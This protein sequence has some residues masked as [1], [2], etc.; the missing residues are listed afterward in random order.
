MALRTRM[1]TP[2]DFMR[3]LSNFLRSTTVANIYLSKSSVCSHYLC[4]RLLG[5]LDSCVEETSIEIVRVYEYE[6]HVDLLYNV[7]YLWN[8]VQKS[9]YVLDLPCIIIDVNRKIQCMQTHDLKLHVTEQ[10]IFT[11]SQVRWLV[12][13]TAG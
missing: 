2:K 13:Q 1:R 9:G 5:K 10:E 12:S 7:Y 4:M 3:D 8:G 11:S 6:I